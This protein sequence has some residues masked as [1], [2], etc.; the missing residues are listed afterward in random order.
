MLLGRFLYFLS[1]KIPFV[2]KEMAGGALDN[3][4]TRE[5]TAVIAVEEENR[6]AFEQ[7]VQEMMKIWKNEYR[8]TDPD[9]TLTVTEEGRKR[10]PWF[11]PWIR[12]SC[13]FFCWKRL[14]AYSI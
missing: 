13:C 11:P 3:V 2:I 14:T 5:S 9:I 12:R 4:I 8:S 6:P 1:K 10:N 7:A